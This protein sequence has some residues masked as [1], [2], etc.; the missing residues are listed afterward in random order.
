MEDF[1]LNNIINYIDGKASIEE[2]SWVEKRIRE[3]KAFAQEFAF[4][5]KA[6]EVAYT[7]TL[8]KKHEEWNSLP[9]VLPIRKLAAAASV[10]F[11]GLVLAWFIFN[12][13]PKDSQLLASQMF[14][15]EYAQLPVSM[16]SAEDSLQLGVQWYNEKKYQEAS[17]IFDKINLAKAK[18]YQIVAAF[19][20]GDFNTALSEADELSQMEDVRVDKS[21][22]LKV[23][24]YLK[25]NNRKEAEALF[26]QMAADD[27]GFKKL[28]AIF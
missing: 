5:L 7:H 27:Y 20:L 22:Y 23:L 4:M 21:V 19:Q 26:R 10:A 14:E 12:K 17:E 28:E 8:Q 16:G 2:K 1:E 13:S 3:D 25:Q 24:V 9:K 11:I 6:K 15:Q 18:E